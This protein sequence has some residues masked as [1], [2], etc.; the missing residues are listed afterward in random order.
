MYTAFT[1]I[2][3]LATF[4]SP[5][6]SQC[7]HYSQV[8]QGVPAEKIS[9]QIFSLAGGDLTLLALSQQFMLITTPSNTSISKLVRFYGEYLFY[10]FNHNSFTL[11]VS[12]VMVTA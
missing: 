6:D 8:A 10:L 2:G 7:T 9:N 4:D 1:R 11:T 3:L 12:M 5:T